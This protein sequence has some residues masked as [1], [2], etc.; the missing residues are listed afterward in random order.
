MK[1]RLVYQ[2][3]EKDCG[4]ACLAMVA[5]FYGLKMPI[6]RWREYT[7]TDREGV[8]AYGII[9][10]A[11]SVGLCAEG[12][13]GTMEE[14][15]KGIQQ[16]TV[17]FPFI[18]HVVNEKQQGHFVVVSKLR[19]GK[20]YLLD[21]DKGKRVVAIQKFSEMWTGNIIT[22]LATEKF[23]AGNYMKGTLTRYFQLLRGQYHKLVSAFILSLAVAFL[24]IMSAFVFQTIVD[25]FGVTVGYYQ[26]SEEE[27]CQDENCGEHDHNH[28]ENIFE[29]LVDY[30]YAEAHHFNIFFI[31]AIILYCVQ[32]AVQFVRSWLMASVSRK[33]DIQLSMRYFAHVMQLPMKTAAHRR[34]GEYLSRFSDTALVKEAVSSVTV[35]V[36]LDILMAVGCGI[37]LCSENV[38]MFMV[39][40]AVMFSYAVIVVGFHR[41]LEKV[42]RR[43]MSKNAEM[44]SGIKESF[45]GIET[46]KVCGA[47]QRVSDKTKTEF[48][49][50]SGLELKESLMAGA[51]EVLAELVEIIGQIAIMWI[52][53]ALVLQGEVTIGSLL[54]FYILLGY[55]SSPVKS[56]IQLQP[57]IQTALIAADRLNDILDMETEDYKKKISMEISWKQMECVNAVFCYGNKIPILKNIN[58]KIERGKHIAIVGESGCG[59]TSLAKILAGLYHVDAGQVLI[60]GKDVGCY[61]LSDLRKDFAYLRQDPFLFADTIRNNLLMGSKCSDDEMMQICKRCQIDG[62]IQKFPFQYDTMLTEMANNLSSG[63]KQRMAIARA[64]ISK[65]KVIVLD[66][67]TSNLDLGT[68]M[69]IMREL[70]AVKELTVIIIAHR[71]ES[72]K[73]CDNIIVMANG[74]IQEMGTHDQLMQKER[75]YFKMWKKQGG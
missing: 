30:I 60:D 6:A 31:G 32:Y 56:L 44:E 14:L 71:L 41:P 42:N 28:H 52:G 7:N 39:A 25:E 51:Q 59:K 72:I 54:S 64:L 65:P 53:F 75:E 48:V 27:D 22:F 2:H 13:A 24:G 11:E 62:V 35:T 29:R 40:V 63:Q 8:N 49:E 10:G 26:Y 57:A 73:S 69:A 38:T 74:T 18:A 20:A 17:A 45:D 15:L 19:N 23:Q 55:F 50:L 34:T 66:E 16:K 3:D 61:T 9:E 12:M 37:I 36:M 33:I 43:C 46:V 47:E 70:F 58:L 68:E 1:C 4:A 5:S 21:P 67:A